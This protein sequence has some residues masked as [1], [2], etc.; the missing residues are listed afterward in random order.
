MCILHYYFSVYGQ[1]EY[2]FAY[3]AYGVTVAEVQVDILTGE[4]Q[5]LRVDILYD[6]GQRY[7][8]YFTYSCNWL[9]KY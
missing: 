4:T 3:N 8:Y 5:L 6:C 1:N 7:D 2:H 9:I